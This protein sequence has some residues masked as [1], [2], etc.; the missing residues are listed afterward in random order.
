[1]GLLLSQA[2]LL[3]SDSGWGCCYRKRGCYFLSRDGGCYFLSRD[4]VFY[5]DIQMTRQ[6]GQS[7]KSVHSPVSKSVSKSQPSVQSVS[8]S[9]TETY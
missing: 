6:T 8:Q 1:M 9:L 4:G 3:F 7:V 2:G 5:N